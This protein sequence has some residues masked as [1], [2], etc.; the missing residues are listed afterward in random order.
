VIFGIA[1]GFEYFISRGSFDLV[2]WIVPVAI[3]CIVVLGVY[4]YWFA[5]R[6]VI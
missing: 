5:T 3:S 1:R 4:L 2:W 6:K